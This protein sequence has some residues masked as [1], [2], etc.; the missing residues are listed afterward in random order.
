M[1]GVVGEIVWTGVADQRF[2]TRAVQSLVHRGPDGSGVFVDGPL[3]LGHTRL[4]LIDLND[5]ASQ[6]MVSVCGRW[7]ISYNGEVYNYKEI[8]KSLEDLGHTFKTTSDTEVV[9]QSW[10]QWGSD[11]VPKFNG[12]FAFAIWDGTE[13]NLFLVRDR[14]GV[15]PLYYFIHS[16]GVVFGSE[17]RAIKLHQ[18]HSFHL[19]R[20]ALTEY[21]TFQNLFTNRTLDTN[22]RIVEPASILRIIPAR[23]EVQRSGYWDFRFD[24]ARHRKT[25]PVELAGELRRLLAQAVKRQLVAD[26]EV[27]T[28]LSGG[29]DSGLVTYLASQQ[30]A[31]LKT[32]TCG[33]DMSSVSG[34]ELAFDERTQA[35]LMSAIFGTEHYE[36]VLKAGDLERSLSQVVESIEEP[37]VGQSYP[38]F[39][40]SRL[41]SRFVKATL[42]GTGGDEIFGGYPWRYFH[43]ANVARFEDFSKRYFNSWQ[44]LMSESEIRDVTRPMHS[45]VDAGETYDVFLSVLSRHPWDGPSVESQIQQC[46]YFEAKT[47]LHGLLVVEDKLSMS[48]GLETRVPLLD[49]DLVDFGLSCPMGL[50]LDLASEKVIRDEYTPGQ[51]SDTF[52]LQRHDGKMILRNVAAEMLPREIVKAAKQGFSAP[53]ATWFRGKSI[54][55]VRR[56]VLAKSSPMFDYLHYSAVAKLVEE[57]L[58]GTRNRRLLIWSLLYLDEYLRQQSQ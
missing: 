53:D 14:Y 17:Q 52:S 10:I 56:R 15:K 29:I 38:N 46:L 2:L 4:S 12:M 9:L 41:A 48:N 44:R 43:S 30:I 54:E 57:H 31:G 34:I 27:G 33:F 45:T 25:D 37:R 6:P 55:F 51:K 26:V 21:L 35:E 50:K 58:D 23:Q 28:F 40:V 32:F 3:G 20:Q 1:C 8:R 5:R 22:I 47:F 7:A 39:F 36:V 49:N 24:N 18:S 19:D 42:A 16:N 13:K 11:C